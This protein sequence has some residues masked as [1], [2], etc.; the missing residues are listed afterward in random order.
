VVALREKLKW[1][2]KKPLFGKKVAVTRAPH[3]SKKLGELLTEKGAEPIYIPTINVAPIEPNERLEGAIDGIDAY[4]CIIF[5]SM[6]GASIF[7]D[8]LFARGKDI[9]SLHGVTVLPIGAATA[10]FL[11][12]RGIAPDFVPEDYISEG[13]IEVLER[14]EV[15][16]RRFLLPRAEQARDVIA[17]YI[18]DHGGVCDVIPVYRTT[19][20]DDAVLPVEKPDIVTFTS[21]STVENF[22]TLFGKEMLDTASVAS[23]GPI[24]TETL[25]RHQVKVDITA[26]RYDI[27]G[28]VDA[29]V[30]TFIGK[31]T[32]KGMKNGLR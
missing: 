6:N 31:R 28:L 26:S 8:N 14:I 32:G 4:S 25:K 18:S 21:A 24:T 5:T 16:G 23:I 13:I 29:I 22:L 30:Q 3:Q 7:L 11:R 20:P 19:L 15:K 17:S 27:E 9:R 1:F 2:E 10:T 12:S